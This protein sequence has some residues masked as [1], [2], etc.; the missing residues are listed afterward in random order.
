MQSSNP[1]AHGKSVQHVTQ[2]EWSTGFCDCCSDV[3][4]CC[5]TCW[6]P[7][8]TFGRIAEIVDRGSTS[9]G[10]SGALYVILSALTGCGC[11]YSYC[12][13]TKMREQYNIEG[14]DCQDC[15]AHFFCELCAL[16]Q[17]YRELQNRGYNMILGWNGN[18][19]QQGRGVPMTRPP[20]VEGGM[21]K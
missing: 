14:N 5:L 8:V 16:T 20:A 1:N 11:L 6:C 7:C 2:Q 19:E 15:L 18:A 12:Y 9:C 10:A 4:N 3:P 17:Q 13:R 21:T